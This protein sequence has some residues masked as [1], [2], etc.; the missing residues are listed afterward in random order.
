MNQKNLNQ[1]FDEYIKQFSIINNETNAE[2]KK[3][4]T[5]FQFPVLMK[6]A[7]A[8]EGPE[9]VAGL[10]I[11]RSAA[12][13]LIDDRMQSMKGMVQLS[14]KLPNTVKELFLELY[15]GEHDTP[16]ERSTRIASFI[17]KSNDLLEQYFPD[18]NRYLQNDQSVMA[19]LFFNDPEHCFMYEGAASRHFGDVIEF[20][21]DW[22]SG[23]H[24]NLAVYQEMCEAVLAELLENPVIRFLDQSRF[25]GRLKTT[26]GELH[27][28]TNKHILLYDI[29]HCMNVYHMDENISFRRLSAKDRRQMLAEQEEAK[30]VIEEYLK[31]KEEADEL[32][33]I[34][35]YILDHIQEGDRIS[36]TRFGSGVICELT[37][38]SITVKYDASE[39]Q[40]KLVLPVVLA[41]RTIHFENADV[42]AR[43]LVYEDILKRYDQIPRYFSYAEERVRPYRKFLSSFE[44][45]QESFL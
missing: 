10:E 25:D 44:R 21:E 23:I 1:I 36:H 38:T 27:P 6:N 13:T 7:L 15:A 4:Q 39:K 41:N 26:P 22:G 32:R 14:R 2:Y 28:D 19:Y 45:K 12:G 20:F 17:I 40:T 9:F 35:E 8:K 37:N 5:A 18:E 3:W 30:P 24:L 34:M 43:I 33:D 16:A 31:A 11:A 42:E 29:M